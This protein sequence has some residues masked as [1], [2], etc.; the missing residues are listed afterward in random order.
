[1]CIYLVD[2]INEKEKNEMN[3]GTEVNKEI[4]HKFGENKI[5]EEK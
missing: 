1:M 3:Y 2:L 5:I 4:E